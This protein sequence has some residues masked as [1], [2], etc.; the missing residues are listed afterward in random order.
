MNRIRYFSPI[1]TEDDLPRIFFSPFDNNPHPLA[2]KASN[3]LQGFL[4]NQ[5]HLN[6]DFTSPDGGKM[7]GVLVIK[8]KNNR[9]GYISAFS[10]M[11]AKSWALPEFIP[12]V[13]NQNEIESFLPEGEKQLALYSQKI[14]TLTHYPE[15]KDLKIELSSLIQQRED[16]LRI[17]NSTHLLN[18][19]NRKSQRLTADKLSEI[20]QQALLKELSFESQEDKR[21][22]NK[23]IEK[24]GNLI[25]NTKK[26][27]QKYE[28]QLVLLKNTRTEL[29]RDLHQRVFS[30][31]TLTN[32]LNEQKN[33]NGFF[34]NS[35]PPGG[36]GDC[37]APKLLQYAHQHQLTPLAI[38]EFWWGS[39]PTEEIR[40]HGQFY[41]SC[42]GKCHPILPFM[43]KGINVQE[44]KVPESSS[45]KITE[46]DIIFEDEVLLVINKPCGLLSIPGKETEDSVFTRIKKRYP[47]AT[48]PLLVHRLDLD[49]SGLLLIAKNSDVHKK[50]QQQFIQRTIKKRYIA[51]LSR[52]LNQT[53]KHTGVIELPLRVDL[54]D[55]PRQIVCYEHGK[56]AKTH[57]EL[58]NRESETTRIYLYPETGRTHQLRVHMAHS[59][60]L[61]TPILGDRLYGK[62]TDRLYLHAEKLSFIHPVTQVNTEIRSEA[63]F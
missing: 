54:D 4:T 43:L 60:G 19:Q 16:D 30:C 52:P 62:A 8:D 5:S 55:R 10:G 58:I 12:P 51:I 45:E 1:P 25:Q 34:E 14:E 27:I 63:P 38:A 32:K 7:F 22:K 47:K 29:S 31:Y 11:L 57:W 42:R 6:H 9:I 49:T 39:S 37:A 48:G 28:N 33:V 46:L 13:F 36:T 17:L 24:W 35:L 26:L 53:I 44:W 61:N 3:E 41:P 20:D 50:L 2:I 15:Y 56:Q 18:K 59:T 23:I 21:E 40:H